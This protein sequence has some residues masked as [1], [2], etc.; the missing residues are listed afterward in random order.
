MGWIPRQYPRFKA[1]LSI[2]LRPKGAT[3]PL[4]TQTA[5]IGLGGCYVESVFTHELS[6]IIDIVLW[7]GD[8]KIIAQ[9]EVVSK[10]PSFGNGLKFTRLTKEGT[11]KLSEYLESLKLQG[12]MMEDP[13]N[14]ASGLRN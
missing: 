2:E 12:L 13:M 6:T 7:V 4:R 1:A 5:D 14:R 9:G 8:T 10:H 3:A 11:E